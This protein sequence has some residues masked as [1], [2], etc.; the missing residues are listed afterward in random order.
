M[1]EQTQPMT[2]SADEMAEFMAYKQEKAKR[3]EAER[4]KQHRE[5]YAQLVDDEVDSTIPILQELEGYLTTVKRQVYDNFQTILDL[6]R[7]V[8]GT[9][10][11]GE[12]RSHTFTNSAGDKRVVLGVNCIDA[13]RDTVEDGIAMVT[14]YITGLA[15]GK[16]DATKLLVDSVM[17]LL[18]RDQKGTIKASRVLQLRRM[19]DE[20]KDEKFI[21]GV[22][23][24]E[25]AYQPTMTKSYIRAEYK[26]SQGAWQ[27]IA[28][29]MTDADLRQEEKQKGGEG[30][31]K[32]E[33]A[34]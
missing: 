9:M 10:K 27:S 1:N 21:E 11:F 29:S 14:A 30:K 19:A 13:Y 8:L 22:R 16:D 6:K 7:E 12:L 25:E 23:I 28:L 5:A 20:S 2:V 33:E 26:D 18:A 24:I 3:E 15:E 32:A 17:R 31:M 4:R 34:K